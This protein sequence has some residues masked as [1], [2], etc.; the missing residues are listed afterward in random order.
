MMKFRDTITTVEEARRLAADQTPRTVFMTPELR[1]QLLKDTIAEF[2]NLVPSI[3]SGD[4]MQRLSAM[5]IHL[6]NDG[7]NFFTKTECHECG[8]NLGVYDFIMTGVKLH[9]PEMVRGVF[10]GDRIVLRINPSG[11]YLFCTSCDTKVNLGPDGRYFMGV[12]GC[13][14]W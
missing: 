1:D 10:V 11:D 13:V 14:R 4:E 12:Y 2:Q 8:R 7:N 3:L 5:G 9:G 6:E